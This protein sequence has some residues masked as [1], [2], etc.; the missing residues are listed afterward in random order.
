[1][2]A[3]LAGAGSGMAQMHAMATIQ[4]IV[5]THARS[6]LTSTYLTGCY[7]GLSVPVIAAGFLADQ[8]GLG[9]VT[10]GFAGVLA[11]LA[12]AAAMT[13]RQA[14]DA[15]GDVRPRVLPRYSAETSRYGGGSPPPWTARLAPLTYAASDEERKTHASPMSSGL[16]MRPSGTVSPTCAMPASSP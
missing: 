1:M 15:P 5:P 8:F 4:R 10:A 3:V 7:L 16:A 13:I 11:A 14:T 2:G 12:A 6:A 9:V